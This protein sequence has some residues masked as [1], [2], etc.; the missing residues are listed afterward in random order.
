LIV[1][2]SFETVAAAATVAAATFEAGDRDGE[3]PFR[4][5]FN[6]ALA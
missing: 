4:V 3:A 2:L 5:G 6:G 1:S